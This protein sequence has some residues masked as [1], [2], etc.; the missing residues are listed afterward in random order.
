M[1]AAGPCAVLCRTTAQ[2]P[3]RVELAD[4]AQEGLAGRPTA[5]VR[6]RGDCSDTR[7]PAHNCTPSL[8]HHTVPDQSKSSDPSGTMKEAPYYILLRSPSAFLRRV[9]A[10]ARASHPSPLARPPWCCCFVFWLLAFGFFFFFFLSFRRRPGRY[11][12]VTCSSLFLAWHY[13]TTML[14]SYKCADS[15][16]KEGAAASL[17]CLSIDRFLVGC[18]AE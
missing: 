13:D 2:V 6:V 16:G 14:L 7:K 4:Q 17:L 5:C 18:R 15:Q 9:A 10:V 8:Q 11:F 1:A 3:A 12:A